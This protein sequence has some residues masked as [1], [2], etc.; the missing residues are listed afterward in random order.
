MS[1]EVEQ[2]RDRASYVASRHWRDKCWKRRPKRR[3]KDTRQKVWLCHHVTLSVK[4]LPRGY[5]WAYASTAKPP[6]ASLTEVLRP[7]NA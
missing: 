1:A 6:P 5:T 4:M 7:P 3:G 2:G